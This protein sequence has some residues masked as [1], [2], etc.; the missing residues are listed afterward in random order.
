MALH[1]V[2]VVSTHGRHE[3]KCIVNTLHLKTTV[4]AK[5]QYITIEE[6]IRLHARK[7]HS[8][9]FFPSFFLL[10]FIYIFIHLFLNHNTA[11]TV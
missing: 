1:S 3:H 4:I 7:E 8:P 6:H 2:I 10:L 9:Y 5:H 11:D